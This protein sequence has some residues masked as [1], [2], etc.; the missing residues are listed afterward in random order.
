MEN[1]RFIPNAEDFLQFPETF[2]TSLNSSSPSPSTG[3][4]RPINGNLPAESSKAINDTG[5]FELQNINGK[6]LSLFLP[7]QYIDI[8]DIKNFSDH[9]DSKTSRGFGG[10]SAIVVKTYSKNLQSTTQVNQI[11]GRKKISTNTVKSIDPSKV[12]RTPQRI[13]NI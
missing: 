1:T 11:L 2:D 6:P 9:F 4:P 10:N 12:S 13:V 3:Q 5:A 8:P 7:G